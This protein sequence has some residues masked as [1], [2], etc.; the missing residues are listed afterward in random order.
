MHREKNKEVFFSRMVTNM[1]MYIVINI[2]LKKCAAR[3]KAMLRKHP[4][5]DG[6]IMHEKCRH[7]MDNGFI[8]KKITYKREKKIVGTVFDLLANQHSQSSP[9]PPE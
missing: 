9:I 1:K 5:W 4:A 3:V 2:N 8:F 6:F 7:S